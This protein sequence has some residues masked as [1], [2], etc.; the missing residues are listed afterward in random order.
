[1]FTTKTMYGWLPIGHMRHHIT[2]VNQCPG[3]RH[4]DEKME[5]LF[6]CMHR[7][8][9]TTRTKAMKELAAQGKKKKVPQHIME[10]VCH[11]IRTECAGKR[12]E[13]K[14]THTPDKRPPYVTRIP[15][16][17]MV[18]SHA[19]QRSSE[20]GEENDLPPAPAMG[21][22]GTKCARGRRAVQGG[23]CQKNRW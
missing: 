20:A 3:C 14:I 6:R 19:G 15:S 9:V 13:P 12:A 22:G 17:R 5:H 16:R 7:T 8:C 21:L 11:V 4:D 2:N 10:A 1:M 18:H 23:G